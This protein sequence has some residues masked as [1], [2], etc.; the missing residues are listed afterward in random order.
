MELVM[1]RPEG[2]DISKNKNNQ[3][4]SLASQLIDFDIF[5]LE[6]NEDLQ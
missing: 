3:D 2:D 1:C 6:Q 5:W 4:S